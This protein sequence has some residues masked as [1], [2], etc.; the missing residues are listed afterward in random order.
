MEINEK[1]IIEEI[2]LITEPKRKYK[3]P[4][5]KKRKKAIYHI[6]EL[7]NIGIRRKFEEYARALSR[8][9]AIYTYAVIGL[10]AFTFML[11]TMCSVG[12]EGFINE[13]SI[14]VAQ[15]KETI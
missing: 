14:G 9:I 13:K 5:R 11:V 1:P 4:V 7:K 12:Y 8:K 10:T 6:D 2:N 15:T 3:K